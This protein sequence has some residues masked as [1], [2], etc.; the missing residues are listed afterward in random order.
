MSTA[1]ILAAE[2]TPHATMKPAILTA[3][4]FAACCLASLIGRAV[5]EIPRDAVAYDRCEA[6]ETNWVYN[7]QGDLVFV[8]LIFR[9]EDRIIAWR[10]ARPSIPV[11]TRIKGGWRYLWLDGDV[12]R[13]VECRTIYETHTQWDRE[14]EERPYWPPEIRRQLS[15]PV[16]KRRASP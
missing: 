2:A 15:L 13:E 3:A 12:T 7:E 4:L 6:V 8:Q 14:T 5:A 11:A 10:M 1:G 16:V 9:E